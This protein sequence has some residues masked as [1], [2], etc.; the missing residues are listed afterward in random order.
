MYI[1]ITGTSELC[2]DF[3]EPQCCTLDFL[4]NTAK[5]QAR[6]SFITALTGEL[7]GNSD[8]YQQFIGQLNNCEYKALFTPGF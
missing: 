7:K 6:N 2:G 4:S 8:K 3:G 5:S 1:Y